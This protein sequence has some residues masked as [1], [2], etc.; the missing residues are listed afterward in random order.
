MSIFNSTC[1]YKV[2]F[3]QNDLKTAKDISDTIGNFT[4]T[5]LSN[6]RSVKGI[7]K[8]DKSTSESEE[9]LALVS[10]QEILNLSKEESIVIGQGELMHPLKVKNGYWYKY[11][12][13]QQMVLRYQHRN[14]IL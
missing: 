6:S 4:T 1:A 3:R 14:E 5:K 8:T 11:K 12:E 7:L 10:A 2:I 9:G 13:F